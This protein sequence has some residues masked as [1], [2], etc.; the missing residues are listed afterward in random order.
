MFLKKFALLSAGSL[1]LGVT[2]MACYGAMPVENNPS[3]PVTVS[4]MFF[5]DAASNQI[6]L[7]DNQSVPVHAKFLIKFSVQMNTA[8]ADAVHLP[9]TTTFLFPLTK[10]GTMISP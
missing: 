4:G 6:P 1:I 10:P 7:Q 9:I 3:P 5:L 8:V 2:A